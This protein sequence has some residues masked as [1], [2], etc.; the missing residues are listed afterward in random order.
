MRSRARRSQACAGGGAAPR[1]SNAT[2]FA[3]TAASAGRASWLPCSIEIYDSS[4]EDMVHSAPNR[5]GSE[6]FAEV[7]EHH[8]RG[9]DLADRIGLIC[10]GEAGS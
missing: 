4:A 8:R 9:Q 6:R 7:V 1:C 2:T 3:F 5:V 10:T